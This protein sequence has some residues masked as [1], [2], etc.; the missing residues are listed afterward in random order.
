MFNDD[1]K[2]ELIVFAVTFNSLKFEFVFK[3]T[4]AIP[5]S[6]ATGF[7]PINIPLPSKLKVTLSS[8]SVSSVPFLSTIFAYKKTTSF[9]CSTVNSNSLMMG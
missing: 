1:L 3:S 8:K 6:K 9:V 7:S 4:V 5:A 2:P